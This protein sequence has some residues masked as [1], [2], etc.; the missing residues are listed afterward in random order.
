MSEAQKGEKNPMY[1]ISPKERMDEETYKAWLYKQQTM[2]RHGEKNP[3]YGK[4]WSEEQRQKQSEAHKK[5]AQQEDYVNPFKDKHHSEE[6]KQKYFYGEANPMYGKT[7]ELN[8]FYGK[9]HSE[10]SKR[11][12]SESKKGKQGKPH[13]EESKRKIGEAQKGEKNHM[14]RK[15]IC[16]ETKQVFDTVKQAL[17]LCRIKTGITQCCKGK[18]KTAGGYHWMFY[19]EYLEQQNK[20]NLDSNNNK[21]A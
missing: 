15:V 6:T 2:E 3:N 8:P 14:A 11:K 10:E 4:T 9:H 16:I 7:G 17:D 1:G 21:V 20:E 19:N 13:S 12:M 18:Q 5:L